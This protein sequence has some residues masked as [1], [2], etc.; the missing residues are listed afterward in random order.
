MVRDI[1]RYLIQSSGGST[2]T[3]QL[4]K[5]QVLTN[6]KTYSRKANELRLAIRLEHLLSKDEIIYTYLN[7]VP[8]GRD[9][10]GANISENTSASYSLLVFHKRFINCTI[11]IP[12]RFVAK[13]IWQ[14]TLQKMEH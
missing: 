2:I 10:N 1:F 6:E 4:V 8:F 14:Y 5:N 9:Y 13:P 11:C 3:Q 7:I 12:Y